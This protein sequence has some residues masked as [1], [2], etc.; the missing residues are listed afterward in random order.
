[1]MILQTFQEETSA[2]IHNL[3]MHEAIQRLPKLT[4]FEQDSPSKSTKSICER[5]RTPRKTNSSQSH[6][7]LAS[8]PHLI[9]SSEH[10]KKEQNRRR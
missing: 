1:M 5:R 7:H 2:N 9:G 10:Q 3:A 4:M 8:S 6:E